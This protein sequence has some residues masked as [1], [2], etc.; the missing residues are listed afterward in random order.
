MAK[1]KAEKERIRKKRVAARRARDAVRRDRVR[2]RYLDIAHTLVTGDPVAFARIGS[3]NPRSGTPIP[4]PGHFD[5][6]LQELRDRTIAS[7]ALRWVRLKSWRGRDVDVD[8]MLAEGSHSVTPNVLFT[9]SNQELWLDELDSGPRVWLHFMAGEKGS[10]PLLI[11]K[12]ADYPLAGWT[13]THDE[14]WCA[15]SDIERVLTTLRQELSP[16]PPQDAFIDLLQ[17]YTAIDLTS[18]LLNP[19]PQLTRFLNRYRWLFNEPL[20]D[21]LHPA[22]SHEDNAELLDALA[23]RSEQQSRMERE[24]EVV[25]RANQRLQSEVQKL[26]DELA[27]VQASV[28][29]TAVQ[30]RPVVVPLAER[31]A[32]LFG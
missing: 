27:L 5:P 7:A 1:D 32:A 17:D 12:S 14:R 10:C 4:V 15:V 2:T 24:A 18:G 8:I 19:S 22:E 30:P 6:L 26:T 11:A 20:G 25:S 3:A 21:L 13:I 16:E 23:E 29:S 28:K 9:Y 31:L